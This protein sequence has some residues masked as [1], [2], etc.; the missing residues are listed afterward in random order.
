MKLNE[1]IAEDVDLVLDL[2]E[3]AET[4]VVEG[5]SIKVQFDS[6]RLGEL[7]GFT[8]YAIGLDAMV[9]YAR[10]ADLPPKRKPGDALMVGSSDWTVLGWEDRGGISEVVLQRPR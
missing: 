6:D 10:T 5:A 8:E 4:A 1:A 3:F 7:S 2:D 9:M